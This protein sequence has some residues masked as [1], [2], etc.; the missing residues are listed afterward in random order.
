MEYGQECYCGDPIVNPIMMPETDCV[1]TCPGNAT[2]LCGGGARLSY[3]EWKGSSLATFN[4]PTGTAAGK[5]EFL[6]GGVVV[7]LIT[8]VNINGKVMF[9]EKYGTGAANTT[10]A[11][12]FDPFFDNDFTKAWRE[13]KGLRTDVFCSAGLVLPDKKGRMLTIGGWSDVST[14]GVRLYTPSGSNG[15][16]GTTQWEEN[17]NEIAL[18]VARWYP[19]AVM[20]ANGTILVI[21]GE[22]GSNDAAQ[23][24]LE[25]LPRM[26]PV[27]SMDWLQRTDPYNLYPFL[28]VLPGGGV[29]VA[30]Y[31]EARILDPVTFATTRELPAVPAGV[32]S[33]K[34]GRTYPLEGTMMIL[35]Q[36]APY[37]DPLRVILC[38]GSTPFTG[39]AIDNC[40]SIAPENATDEWLIER[41]VSA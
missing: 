26:G 31:N 38:G 40:V 17:A 5:Y 32:T 10:G 37:T 7:P 23:P 16:P 15:V 33:T 36:H 24:S 30:Y 39:V 19:S 9:L 4:Y 1:N 13:L 41:M 27:L 35:P 25:L 34:G 18:Q 28:A 21:G 12:E 8:T 11:Y 14:T 2:A 29:L 20:L 6:I 22:K 3:Y